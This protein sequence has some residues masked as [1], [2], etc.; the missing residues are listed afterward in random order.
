M[1]FSTGGQLALKS[2]EI[3]NRTDAMLGYWDKNLICRYANQ[4][5]VKWFGKKPD[6][7]IDKITMRELLGPLFQKNLPYIKGA[8]AG[9]QQVFEREILLPSGELKTSIA[10][11]YPHEKEGAIVGF[12]VHVADITMVKNN[13]FSIKEPVPTAAL[14]VTPEMLTNQLMSE[15][16]DTLQ[17]QIFT[18]FPGIT[19]LAK[20]H[21]VS[22]TKLKTAFKARYKVTP[23]VFYRNLQM[24]TAEQYIAGNQYTPKQLASLFN[25]ASIAN[26]RRCYAAYCLRKDTIPGKL[27]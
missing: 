3:A 18:K 22:G 8:L 17:Q 25:F 15:V 11:Y 23:F 12:F 19:A 24:Q 20:Q 2:L 27:H 4:A 7:M 6:E 14:P 10:T 1:P 13:F 9:R 26:F 21:F 5:Y 16:A